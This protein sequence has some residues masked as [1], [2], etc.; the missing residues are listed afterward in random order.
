[1]DFIA[2]FEE[3]LSTMSFWWENIIANML[4]DNDLETLFIL[5]QQQLRTL[6]PL[7]SKE[8]IQSSVPTLSLLDK[9]PVPAFILSSDGIFLKVNQLFADI[10]ASDALYMQGKSIK[11]FIDNIESEIFAILEQFEHNDGHYEKELYVKG[12]FY[13]TY[14]RALKNDNEQIIALMTVWAEVTKLKRR[15]RVLELNNLRLQEYLYIDAVTG[16]ANRLAL[17]Q[18][19][20]ETQSEQKKTPF[21]ALM[22]D[23]DDFKKFNQTYSYSQGD[24]VL[25]EIAE[26]LQSYLNP[27]ESMLYRLNSAQFVIVMPN[28]SELTAYT[29]AERLRIAIYDA[30]YFFEEG[31]HDRLTATVAIYKPSFQESTSFSEIESRLRFAIKNVKVQEKNKSISLE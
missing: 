14:C 27:K 2:Y 5:G 25:K 9:L 28:A 29:L 30:A 26:L 20:S 4:N 1:V 31:V 22:F 15:E 11:S 7:I 6:T 10:Y 16:A 12:H 3:N 21:Y 18:W 19:L 17:E 8:S 24:I 13:N 23:L